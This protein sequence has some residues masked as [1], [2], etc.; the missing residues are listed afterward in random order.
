MIKKTYYKKWKR[1]LRMI[2]EINREKAKY[3][4]I[5]SIVILKA[6]SIKVMIIGT[7]FLDVST[8][9]KVYDYIGCKFPEGILN[10]EDIFYF[11]QQDIDTILHF[12]EP[13]KKMQEAF[14]KYKKVHIK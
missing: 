12:G 9:G 14:L 8:K 11:Q 1:I 2:N 10:K 7:I 5:G 4:P 13:D 3:C 6:S